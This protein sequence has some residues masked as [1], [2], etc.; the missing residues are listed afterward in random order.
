MKVDKLKLGLAFV[1]MVIG[2]SLF[3]LLYWDFVRDTVVVP[4]YYVLWV[5]GLILK[6][7]PQWLFVALLTG[8]SILIS[9]NTLRDIRGKPAGKST[10]VSPLSADTRYQHWRRLYD[11][12]YISRFSRNLFITDARK[13]IL[14][15]LAYERGIDVVQAEALVRS[16]GLDLPEG[17]RTLIRQRELQEAAPLTSR[18]QDAISRLRRLLSRDKAQPNPQV[19]SL[20]A[21]TIAFL[22]QHLEMPYG[23]NQPE[24]CFQSSACTSTALR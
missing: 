24:P 17:I 18:T 3:T 23:G 21:E 8:I 22:E 10:Q 7:I 6:S 2:F 20:V 9:L 13:L 5:G 12:V 1:L 11:N 16:G 15:I 19:D 14:S 4:I